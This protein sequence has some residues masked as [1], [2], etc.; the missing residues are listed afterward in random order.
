MGGLRVKVVSVMAALAVVFGLAVAPAGA[1]PQRPVCPGPA[2][3]GNALCHARVVTNANGAPQA[4]T[5]P[6]GY[7]PAQFRG[8]YGL[9]SAAPTAQ[10]LAIVDAFDDPSIAGD[11]NTYSTQFGLPLCNSTNPCF[12][13]VNQSGS[14]SGPFPRTDSGWAMEI[15]LD[16]EVAHA[17]CPNCKILL[18]E[19]S[20]NSLSNL[21][22]AVTTAAKLGAT[23]ISNSYG[24][25]EFSSELSGTYAAPYEQ[26]GVAVTVS[27][28]DNGYGSF[29]FPA[30][31]SSVITVGGTTL[32]L[33]SGNTYGSESAWSGAGSGCS[34]YVVAPGWQSFLRA[35]AG[36][37]GT[38]DVAADANP[39]TGAA[40]YDSVKYQ[41][42]SGWMQIGG[43][44]L[45]A[46]LIAGVYALAGG[47]PSG[48]SG[49]S[50]LYPHL[51]DG[52]V[53]HDVT[54]GSNGNC[55][56]L[57][58]KGAAGYDGP[59]GVGTPLGIGAF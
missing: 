55:S 11:L 4:T 45:S 58:C 38:A 22:A 27:S 14:A 19:A 41:G 40:V 2:S 8:A 44:S 17:A 24:G 25:S 37:R 52:T 39:A 50:G 42:R 43:T 46:P 34:Q 36:K 7:G 56:T 51:G 57:M 28:G 30:A 31:L 5:A 6:R 59:T 48:T 10:T 20:S 49:A 53:L 54:A 26:P 13:K 16:V 15:A 1:V 47:L 3:A 12:Q 32:N 23:E 33:G 35:C 18:V 9:P 21:A 29:G